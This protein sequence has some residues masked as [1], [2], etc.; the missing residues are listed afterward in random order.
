MYAAP[1]VC[2]KDIHI[3][4]KRI[5]KFPAQPSPFLGTMENIIFAKS[6]RKTKNLKSDFLYYHQILFY[7]LKGPKV[8]TGSILVDL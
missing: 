8:G 6:I 1:N 5:L 3:V 4:L 2:K 7:L